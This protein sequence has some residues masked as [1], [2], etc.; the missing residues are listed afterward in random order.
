MSGCP[1]RWELALAVVAAALLL[2]P[3]LWAFGLI[4]PWEGHYA[5]VGRRILADSDWVHLRW[6]DE[7]FRSK[8]ALAPWL[9]AAGLRA[10]GFAA[11]GGFAGELVASPAVLWAVRLPFAACAIAGVACVWAMLA[12]LVS[13]RAAWI[14]L[15]AL[16]S[17][18]FYGLVA[19][20]AITDMPMV[21]ST[22]GALSLFLLAMCD[23][24][25]S[26]RPLVWRLTAV[27][28]LLAVLVALTAVQIVY[29][30]SYLAARPAAGSRLGVAH[31]ALWMTLP[32]A[33]AALV[34]GVLTLWVWPARAR[35]DV[36]LL[37]AYVL[38]GAGVLAKGPPGAALAVGV[39]VLYIAATGQWRLVLRLRAIEGALV[40]LLVAA[41]WH[42]A[43]VLADGPK[44]LARY[45][46]HHWLDRAVEG[47]HMVNRAGEGTIS[48]FV[49]QLGVGLWP[50][51][52]L[53]PAAV[54]AAARA[55]L[56]APAD[57]VRLLALIWAVGGLVLFT[58]LETKF[59]HY[60]LP[61]V[62]G[63]AIL[64]VLWLDDVAASRAR[65]AAPAIALG[66]A[67]A[68]LVTWD[69]VAQQERIL[70]L[71]TYRYDRPW[72][73]EPPWGVDLST[74]LFAFGALFCAAGAALWIPRARRAAVAGIVGL[75]IAFGLWA[76]CRY[77][78]AAAPHWGQGQLH[79]TYYRMRQVQGV[80][81]HYA[82]AADLARDW[83]AA[84]RA[85]AV[86]TFVPDGLEVGDPMTVV[87]EAGAARG[88]LRGWVGRVAERRLSIEVPAAEVEASLPVPPSDEPEPRGPG[89]R[90]AEVIAD[91]LIAWNLYWR[92]ELFWSSGELW[93]RTADTRTDFGYRDDAGLRAYLARPESKGRRFFVISER[94]FARR[95]RS[96]M[97][98]KRARD[99]VEIVDDSSHKFVLQTFR[100]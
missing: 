96:M 56:R 19:R 50:L 32:F 77:L 54:L 42:V 26:L 62:P 51:V 75:S 9:I 59:H 16:A 30:A 86:S 52:A 22:A 2:L 100:L 37:A 44:F 29:D 57:H 12:R 55:P 41:P 20:Q 33:V 66:V 23:G 36:Y 17:V 78:P 80:H 64:V 76:G 34:V 28:V 60:V 85:V 38:V 49:H 58:S 4:D 11:G 8:P 95:L 70:E 99:S 5:E 3:G 43:M 69:V 93:G 79:A 74:E 71:F 72:P 92:A 45:I 61:A 65:P 47:V 98:T 82:T 97:P 73:S 27:H 39:V 87:V 63:F 81:L 31:P 67:A 88:E 48:Y 1:R 94:R 15:A 89:P 21:A 7:V 46:G 90:W 14:A 18:P 6:R 91:R 10:H 24:D 40:A 35:R 25:R 83:P 84:G 68:A 13:R 53:V